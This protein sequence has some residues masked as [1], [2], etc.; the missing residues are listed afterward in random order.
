MCLRDGEIVGGMAGAGTHLIVG[1]GHVHAPV[2][3]VL[4]APMR[5]NR[6]RQPVGIRCQAAEV[7][8]ALDG[9]LAPDAARRFDHGKGFQIRPLFGLVRAGQLSE[10]VAAACFQSAMILPTVSVTVGAS[11]P[12]RLQNSAKK[13]RMASAKIG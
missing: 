5:P 4:D 3:A 9:C 11:A 1:E 2:Q 10:G 7:E 13:S 8:A 6:S 12:G